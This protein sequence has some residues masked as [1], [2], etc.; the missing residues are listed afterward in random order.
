MNY[1]P[2]PELLS[3][4]DNTLCSI[5]RDNLENLVGSSTSVSDEDNEDNEEL[6]GEIDLKDYEVESTIVSPV[7]ENGQEKANEETD[8][9]FDT[10]GHP[11]HKNPF[12]KG[13][14]TSPTKKPSLDQDQNENSVVSSIINIIDKS[15]LNKQQFPQP[16]SENEVISEPFSD[17][18]IIKASTVFSSGPMTI[19]PRRS[20]ISHTKSPLNSPTPVKSRNNSGNSSATGTPVCTPVK[21]QSQNQSQTST[22]KLSI[23][24]SGA[25]LSF[26]VTPVSV[27]ENITKSIEILNNDEAAKPVQHITP[28]RPRN[29]IHKPEKISPEKIMASPTGSP[30]LIAKNTALRPEDISFQDLIAL[31]RKQLR[32]MKKKEVGRD[33]V[34]SRL[35]CEEGEDGGL[36]F[37]FEDFY[38]FDD[39]S[40]HG[41]FCQAS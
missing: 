30:S 35:L 15:S 36:R 29:I 40:C 12:K 39:H 23:T 9:K 37:F 25:T 18:E 2:S 22:P 27:Q 26:P 41:L 4:I 20:L 33:S 5:S 7:T 28:P 10:L 24:Q 14:V 1:N 21:G 17:D 11:I 3:P 6:I 19:S 38:E 13:G 8:R 16:L 32:E 31:R 34:T